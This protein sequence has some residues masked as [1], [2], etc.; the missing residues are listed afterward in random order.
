MPCQRHAR[1]APRQRLT[2]IFE[3]SSELQG[4]S[5]NLCQNMSHPVISWVART[6]WVCGF[7]SF[8][9]GCPSE[10]ATK[11]ALS[12]VLLVFLWLSFETKNKNR[13]SKQETLI[14]SVDPCFESRPAVRIALAESS[15]GCGLKKFARARGSASRRRGFGFG[16]RH[17][18]RQ[19]PRLEWFRARGK[20]NAWLF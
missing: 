13:P 10:L 8:P 18:A 12:V 16:E 1:R 2:G 7:V 6:I 9:F 19:V 5:G 14:G 3:N 4:T 20:P 17:M 11:M 15:E